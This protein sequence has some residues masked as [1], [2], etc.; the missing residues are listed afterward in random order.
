MIIKVAE[1]TI[2]PNELE[3]VLNAIRTF[4]AAIHAHEP[5]TVYEAFRRGDTFEFIHLMKFPTS[6][7]EQ[8]HQKADYTQTF[9]GGSLS[10]LR[11]PTTLYRSLRDREIEKGWYKDQPEG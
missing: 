8:H 11:S 3:T 5:E 4:I 1:Y 10:P 9:V 2:K 7:A 6:E